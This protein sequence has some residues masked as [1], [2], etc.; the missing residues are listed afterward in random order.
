M[1]VASR[2]WFVV[3]VVLLIALSYGATVTLQRAEDVQSQGTPIADQTAELKTL[4]SYIQIASTSTVG[5][6]EPWNQAALRAGLELASQTIESKLDVI[7][8]GGELNEISYDETSLVGIKTTSTGET[9]DGVRNDPPISSWFLGDKA[10]LDASLREYVAQVDTLLAKTQK[11]PS[12]DEVVEWSKLAV[13]AELSTRLGEVLDQAGTNIREIE[14]SRVDRSRLVAS[15]CVVAAIAMLFIT[16]MTRSRRQLAKRSEQRRQWAEKRFKTLLNST[17]ELVLVVNRQAKVLM[18]GSASMRFMSV[19]PEELIGKTV[20]ELFSV[21]D[22]QPLSRWFRQLTEVRDGV[23]SVPFGGTLRGSKGELLSVEMSGS[24]FSTDPV[25][26]GIILSVRDVSREKRLEQQAEFLNA[27]D[28]LTGSPR[29]PILYEQLE[30]LD[31]LEALPAIGPDGQLLE[32]TT[33]LIL[34]RV[35]T[36]KLL[37]QISSSDAR[38]QLLTAI[39]TRVRVCADQGDVIART[40]VDEFAVLMYTTDG[41]KGVADRAKRVVT[42]I[43]GPLLLDGLSRNVNCRVGVAVRRMDQPATEMMAQASRALEHASAHQV[44]IQFYTDDLPKIEPLTG[45]IINADVAEPAASAQ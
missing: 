17:N 25:I 27:R 1:G 37:D 42:N 40:D 33:A 38:E 3:Q 34:I 2:L 36:L 7:L 22:E 6:A 35:P 11:A 39:A 13:S 12:G 21:G 45:A 28:P 16:I 29:R 32:R 18:V 26:R 41:I 20:F 31:L 15:G 19:E 8:D 24:D 14:Q 30:A 9:I 5:A 44:L 23:S 43:N 10:V 4:V